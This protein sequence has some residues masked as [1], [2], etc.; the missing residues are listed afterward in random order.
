MVNGSDTKMATTII[1]TNAAWGRPS[2]S[3][4]LLPNDLS[5]PMSFK[6]RL[7]TPL[8]GSS[9]HRNISV[10][11]RTDAAHGAMS[12][13]RVDP[14][15]REYLVEQLG[16]PQGEK[17]RDGHHDDDP[18]RRSLQDAGRSG[19]SNRSLK[20]FHPAGPSKKPFGLKC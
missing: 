17:H 18:D 2:Q 19:S 11:I 20:F 6:N 14:P 1:Q 7:I 9:A 4:W 15:S 12:A 8:F 5:T 16:E 3:A 13:H 10:V